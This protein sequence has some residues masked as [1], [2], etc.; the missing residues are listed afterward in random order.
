MNYNVIGAKEKVPSKGHPRSCSA[1]D[2][3]CDFIRPPLRAYEG[4][5]FNWK[6]VL[7]A[8]LAGAGCVTALAGNL[9]FPAA[10]V[11]TP[12]AAILLA[13]LY[14]VPARL[15]STR[16]AFWLLHIPHS[17]FI[18]DK[19]SSS[20]R[21]RGTTSESHTSSQQRCANRRR[22]TAAASAAQK[23]ED[24]VSPW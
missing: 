19:G 2:Y 1:T 15:M 4:Q 12:L 20:G 9:N 21:K 8:S 13:V 7:A 17:S 11:F 16:V 24:C 10:R 6:D 23:L 3:Y 5:A 14:L 22:V 18:S